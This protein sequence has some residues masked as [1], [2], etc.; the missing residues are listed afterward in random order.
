MFVID[1][2]TSHDILFPHGKGTGYDPAQKLANPVE[3]KALPSTMKLIPRS[4]WDARIKEQDEQQSSLQHVRRRGNGGAI[5]PSLDQGQVGYCWAH[6]TTM[7]VMLQRAVAGEPYIPLSAYAI[8]AT[9]KKGADEGGWCGLSAQFARDKGIPSQA[10]W[11]Q[12]D[13]NYKQYDKP[14]TWANAALH[15]VTED[16]VDLTKDVYDQNLTVDQI[17]TCLLLNVPLA[18]DYNEWGHSIAALR[19]VKIEAGSYGPLILNSWGDDW[20]DKGEGVIQK[21]WGVDGA[22]GIV[23]TPAN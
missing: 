11:P 14:E 10:I 21:G 17:A 1:D 16:W 19:W 12:G 6:S 3:M 8:A 13:R 23:S 18:V 7:A 22:V 20:G 4:E 2:S 5:I 9:I 15:K